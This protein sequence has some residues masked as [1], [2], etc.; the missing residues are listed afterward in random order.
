MSLGSFSILLT[1]AFLIAR[2]IW[3]A[4][5]LIVTDEAVKAKARD[6]KDTIK[7]TPPF[8]KMRDLEIVVHSI[9]KEN[10]N[11][12][13]PLASL[14]EDK[15]KAAPN[16]KA[17][18]HSNSLSKERRD[19]FRLIVCKETPEIIDLIGK[20]NADRTILIKESPEWAGSGG[21]LVTMTTGMDSAVGIHEL[22]HTFGFADEY[23]FVST[24]EADAYC[25]YLQKNGAPNLAVFKDESPYASDAEARQK[26]EGHIPWYSKIKAETFITTGVNL[27]TPQKNVIGLFQVGT[28]DRATE[29][30]KSWRP[31][32]LPN[33]MD[34][35]S[36]KTIHIPEVYWQQIAESLGI[37]I[38]SETEPLERNSSASSK[39]KGSIK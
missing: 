4:K 30:V 33:V 7:A 12:S 14:G 5:I 34:N 8:S 39:S 11:C 6:V 13:Y 2:P 37:E 28:C 15:T 32:H 25:P 1:C 35:V 10:L 26:H 27:G 18:T 17:E 23:A 31:G 20:E 16:T 38:L 21:S 22:M 3:A 19:E 36:S 29:K 24:V 9:L